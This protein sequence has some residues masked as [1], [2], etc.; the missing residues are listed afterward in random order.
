MWMEGMVS[1]YGVR[2]RIR[3]GCG[4]GGEVRHV[5]VRRGFRETQVGVIRGVGIQGSKRRLS[6]DLFLVTNL[7]YVPR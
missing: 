6:L 1:P 7:R 5:G 3:E 4:T 2:K